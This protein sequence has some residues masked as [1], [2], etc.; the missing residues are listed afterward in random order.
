MKIDKRIIVLLII[1][2]ILS[3]GI[4]YSIFT[5]QQDNEKPRINNTTINNTT[6]K[7]ATLEQKTT[8]NSE[9]GQYGYCAVC[10][11]ALTSSEANNE[12]TQGKVCL[13]CANNPYY[14][15]GEGA[16]YANKKL[17]EAYPEDY[18]WMYEDTSNYEH[19]YSSSMT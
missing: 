4:G 16:E 2:T 14:Q 7:N 12:Y 13:S 10:G 17:A 6:I 3:I 18:E 8:S 15:S 9:S 1:I 19:D 11:K 5:L